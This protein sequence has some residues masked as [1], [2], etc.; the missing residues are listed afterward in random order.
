MNARRESSGVLRWVADRRQADR[1]LSAAARLLL[2]LSGLWLFGCAASVGEEPRLDPG[3]GGMIADLAE[4]LV[5]ARQ[6][7]GSAPM[8]A[9]FILLVPS[10]ADGA[11]SG[12]ARLW[13]ACGSNLDRRHLVRDPCAPAALDLHF[14]DT[15]ER[16]G[17]LD[18]QPPEPE[19]RW[20]NGLAIRAVTSV[21]VALETLRQLAATPDLSVSWVGAGD[22]I[23]PLALW[24]GTRRA[25]AEQDAA[26]GLRFRARVLPEQE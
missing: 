2:P 15:R 18:W 20:V 22:G 12:G 16:L 7:G 5:F 25:W 23:E 13:V 10:T 19:R 1:W 26:A 8:P 14:G 21:P 11:T 9:H 17:G 6:R 24:S 3:G 4:P